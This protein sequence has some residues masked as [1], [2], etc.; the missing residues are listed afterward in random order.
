MFF[1]I[2][3]IPGVLCA[4]QMYSYTGFI[5]WVGCFWTLWRLAFSAA[6]IQKSERISSSAYLPPAPP[7]LVD[8][9]KQIKLAR[10]T[11]KILFSLLSLSVFLFLFS[12]C[13]LLPKCLLLWWKWMTGGLPNFHLQPLLLLLSP[14]TSSLLP[15]L[16]CQKPYVWHNFKRSEL[17]HRGK[18][19]WVNITN[20]PSTAR[21]LKLTRQAY[22]DVILCL[23]LLFLL[24]SH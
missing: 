9:D 15:A 17:C 23:F 16:N 24:C 1:I 6:P 2:R 14:I 10:E 5:W 8:P 19:T 11:K 21:N 3:P 4:K 7:L 12:C 20:K 18:A 22:M 13:A